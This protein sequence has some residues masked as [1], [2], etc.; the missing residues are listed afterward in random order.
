M[1]GWKKQA[2][3]EDESQEPDPIDLD[4]SPTLPQIKKA[5]GRPAIKETPQQAMA[6]ED[7]SVWCV[8]EQVTQTEPVLY[9]SQNKKTYTI[10][11]AL[12]ELLNRTEQ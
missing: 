6:Q 4:E 3:Q 10:L 5:V 12:V 1:A 2:I 7:E 8:K 9:N 11:E